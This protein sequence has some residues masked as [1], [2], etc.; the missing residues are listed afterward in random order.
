[1]ICF[2]EREISGKNTHRVLSPQLKTVA[3]GLA[4]PHRTV[5]RVAARRALSIFRGVALGW[6]AKV[7]GGERG[8]FRRIIEVFMTRTILALSTAML[9]CASSRFA[10]ASESGAITGGVGGAVAGAVVGGPVGAVVGGVGG[11]AIGNSMT[12]H[13]ALSSRIWLPFLPS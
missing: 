7:T 11:A 8:E 10:F 2:N 3:E 12:N 4:V 6:V 5:A 1:V 9:I 13:Q